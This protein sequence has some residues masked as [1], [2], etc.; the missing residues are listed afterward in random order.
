[1]T[2]DLSAPD[3][4]AEA[5]RTEPACPP[6]HRQEAA[7]RPVLPRREASDDDA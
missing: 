5:A 4:A 2:A 1:M 7:R 3:A 6:E